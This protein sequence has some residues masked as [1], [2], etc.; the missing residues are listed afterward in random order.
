MI[1]IYG[2]KKSA[3]KLQRTKRFI[4]QVKFPFEIKNTLLKTSVDNIQRE[5]T[6]L[7]LSKHHK[8]NNF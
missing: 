3:G 6:A 2:K 5:I 8:G 7:E 4:N 1:S